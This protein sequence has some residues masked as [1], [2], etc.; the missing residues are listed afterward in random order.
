MKVGSTSKLLNENSLFGNYRTVACLA[1]QQ[2]CRY[3]CK[4]TV[5]LFASCNRSHL[6]AVPSVLS[7]L[8]CKKDFSNIVKNLSDTY[9]E[10]SD[11]SVLANAALS[12]ASLT[13]GGHTRAVD[14]RDHLQRVASSLSERVLELLAAEPEKPAGTK[15]KS[16]GPSRRSSKRMRSSDASA[17]T[18]SS[19]QSVEVESTLK[20]SKSPLVCVF[21]PFVFW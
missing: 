8:K 13:R 10:S 2:K 19:S 3:I 5:L 11:E 21:F 14:A 12:L 6:A 20:T 18:A 1:S 7:L 16:R 15:R 4:Y 17:S 9:I